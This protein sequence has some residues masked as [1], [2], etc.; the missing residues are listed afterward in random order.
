[1]YTT[2]APTTYKTKF[3]QNKK[4][5]IYIYLH[6]V[7]IIIPTNFTLDRWGLCSF[8]VYNVFVVAGHDARVWLV[9]FNVSIAI[10]FG[11]VGLS[12]AQCTL[13]KDALN[14]L[15]GSLY[16]LGNFAVH[17]YPALRLWY[18]K[19]T[20]A[21]RGHQIMLS[22]A[23]LSCYLASQHAEAVYGCPLPPLVLTWAALLAVPLTACVYAATHP[24]H[25][26]WVF[27]YV[28]RA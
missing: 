6:N 13:L 28:D 23:L 8:A 1:M 14:D 10:I 15:G 25:F 21:L 20:E 5:S 26:S 17:Y 16:C 19:P 12:I 9:C 27:R 18:S 7:K 24:A 11:V 2:F 4:M 3:S 22:L